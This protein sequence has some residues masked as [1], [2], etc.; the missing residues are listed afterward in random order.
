ME[1]FLI[2]AIEIKDAHTI[3]VDKG[4]YKEW[5]SCQW[6][7]SSHEIEKMGR[8]EESGIGSKRK[9]DCRSPKISA[10]TTPNFFCCVE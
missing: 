8:D 4:I 5:R 3:D 2:S 7:K 9:V 1:Y 6:E 10:L